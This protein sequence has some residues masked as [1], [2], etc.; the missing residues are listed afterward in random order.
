MPGC[1]L[2]RGP[3]SPCEQPAVNGPPRTSY[4]EPWGSEETAVSDSKRGHPGAPGLGAAQSRS[5]KGAGRED[6]G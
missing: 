4:Q 5:A 3:L 1:S 2:T 6:R